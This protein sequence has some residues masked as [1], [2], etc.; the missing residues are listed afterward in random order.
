MNTKIIGEKKWLKV[1]AAAVLS[2]GLLS[3]C[4]D[5][6]NDDTDINVNDP[7]DDVELNDDMNDDVDL[8]DDNNDDLD[9]NLEDD[10]DDD[11]S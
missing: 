2:I 9:D 6:D 7:V 1:G 4:G 5:G 10:T 11:A 3:A 8:N